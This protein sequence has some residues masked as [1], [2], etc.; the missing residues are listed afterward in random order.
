VVALF[1]AQIASAA[2]A[3]RYTS[4][5]LWPGRLLTGC[6][7][8]GRAELA[9]VVLDIAYVHKHSIH[10]EVFY[11]LM[12][13]A[14]WLNVKLPLTIHLLKPYYQEPPPSPS[15]LKSQC[16]NETIM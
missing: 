11:T 7:M 16:F 9:Y 2:L 4:G 8:L 5:M 13:S 14:F 15:S 6:G 10:Q 1:I 12:L 3:A